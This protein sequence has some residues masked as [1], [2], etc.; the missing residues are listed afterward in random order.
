MHLA[1]TLAWFSSLAVMFASD[2]AT[3][4]CISSSC[5]PSKSRMP[6]HPLL[7]MIL[8]FPHFR[9]NCNS[10]STASTDLHSS[11]SNSVTMAPGLQHQR[12]GV[13]SHHLM[14]RRNEATATSQPDIVIFD[15]SI[16]ASSPPS[17]TNCILKSS[18]AQ[19]QCCGS[20]L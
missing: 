9:S 3:S 10:T 15:N 1:R 16:I 6:L 18:F 14:I 13:L 4:C 20:C 12:S 17:S 11:S 5:S 19:L 8:D 7:L 2:R